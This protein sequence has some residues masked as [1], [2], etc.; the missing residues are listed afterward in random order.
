MQSLNRESGTTTVCDVLVAGGGISGVAAAVAAARTGCRVVLIEKE[1]V[2]GGTGTRGMLNTIC[3]LYLNGASEPSETL[4]EGL[5]R[6]FVA[7]LRA[8]SPHRNATRIGKVYVLPYAVADFQYALDALCRSVPNLTVIPEAN[9]RS[10]TAAGGLV[11]EVTADHAGTPLRILPRVAV[12]CTGTGDLACLAGAEFDLAPPEDIQL[13]GF[14]IRLRGLREHVD[15]LELKVP[16]VLAR[17][18]GDRQ[19]SPATRFTTFTPGEAPDE[20]YL[21]FN[22]SG[23]A[24]PEREEAVRAEAERALALLAERLPAFAGATVDGISQGVFD[25]EGRR[26]CG[27]YSLTGE[28]VLAARKFADGVVRNAWPI[29][30]WDRERGPVYRYVPTGE[31][32]E[33]PFR[34]LTVKHFANL[35]VAGRCISVTH[36]ALGST[37]VMGTCLALGE[38]AGRAAGAYIATGTY[39]AFPVSEQ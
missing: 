13:A 4:N 39:S 30:L 11:R 27:E 5:T 7:A 20:G 38:Q 36:E 1:A 31:Y 3:G 8:R 33:I 10:A 22:V 2:M 15:M 6:E 37:R 14:V 12:D 23:T 26:V 16:Y 21:K 28:D 29:E 35:L 17:L 25:R 9:I 32:Y 19:L 24:G 34:C 18:V